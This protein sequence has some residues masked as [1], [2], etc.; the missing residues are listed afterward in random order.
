MNLAPRPFEISDFSGGITDNYLQGDP[1]RS[2]TLDNFFITVDKKLEERPAFRPINATAYTLASHQQRVN[3]MYSFINETILMGSSGRAMSYLP[4]LRGLS[5]WT[6]IT[7]A[8]G[9][10]VIQGGDVNSQITTGEFQRQI[11][12][13]SDGTD[14]DQGAVPSKLYRD[15]GN[16]WTAQTAGLPRSYAKPNYTNE[17]LLSTCINLANNLRTSFISHISDAQNAVS[18]QSLSNHISYTNLHFNKDNYSLSFFQAYTF[19]SADPEPGPSPTPTPAPAATD[20]ASLFTLV[21]ALA[22]AF[23][24]H[25]TDALG[26]LNNQATVYFP[27]AQGF[28]AGSASTYQP[29]YHINTTVYGGNSGTTVQYPPRGPHVQLTNASLPTTLLAAAAQLDDIYQKWNWHR[30]A[31]WTHSVY[32]DPAVFDKYAPTLSK[33]GAIQFT[34]P[35]PTVTPDFS[36][37]YAYTNNLKYLLNYHTSPALI[38]TTSAHKE[39]TDSYWQYNTKVTLPDC[40]DQDSMGLMIFW[41]RSMYQLHYLDASTPNH[42]AVTFSTTNGSA[43]ITTVV[44]VA[45]GAAFTIPSTGAGGAINSVL[46]VAA[47]GFQSFSGQNGKIALVTT[48]GSGTATLDRLWT[49]SSSSF[50]GYV[51]Q[52]IFHTSYNPTTAA[53]IDAATSPEQVTDALVNSIWTYGTEPKSWLIL[54]SDFYNAFQAHTLYAN[55]HQ[56]GYVPATTNTAAYQGV[57]TNQGKPFFIPTTASYTYAFFFSNKYTVEPNGLSY[58]VAGNPVQTASTTSA[59]SLPLGYVIPTPYPT[60]FNSTP[61]LATRANVLSNL[62]VLTNDAKSNYDLANVMLNIYRTIDGGQTYYLVDQVTNGT[63]T[64]SDTSSDTLSVAGKTLLPTRQQIYTTGGNVG[65]DQPPQCKFMHIL[66]GTAYYGAVT[67]SGQFFPNRI[68]QAVQLAPDWC[69]ASFND[70]LDDALTGISSTRSNVV[71]F[72]KNSLYRMVGG[73]NQV[74]QGTLT[75]ERISD[76]TGALNAKSIVRT[77]IGIFF[78]GTDGFYYTDGYQIIKISIDLDKTYQALTSTDNQKRAIAGTYDKVTRRVWWSM[79]VNPTDSENSVVYVFYLNY[80]VKPSGTF[81]T[82]SNYSYFWPASLTFIQGVAYMGDRQGFTLKLDQDNKDDSIVSTS[83]DPTTWNTVAIPFNWTSTAIDMGTTFMKKWVTKLHVVGK[84]TGNVSAIPYVLRD[85]NQSGAG[86]KAMSPINYNVNLWWGNPTVTWGDASVR[87]QTDGKMDLWRWFPQGALRSDFIQ[88]KIVPDTNAVVYSS[89]QDYPRAQRQ[90]A[91]D[92]T[93]K[94]ATIDNQGVF[95]AYWPGDCV[96]MNISFATDNYVKQFPILSIA[97]EDTS[98]G[99]LTFSDPTNLAINADFCNGWQIR[100]AR[101]NQ[102]MTLTAVDLHF[103]FYGQE[104]ETSPGSYSNSGPGSGG[105]NPP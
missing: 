39:S 19:T 1:R 10:Q 33:V 28:P 99:V 104:N 88:L 22:Q 58:L 98:L 60:Y 55:V 8:G 95:F 65:S 79:R 26:G 77:E 103:A 30:K 78:A 70:D 75:H 90:V 93:A 20:Q 102:R 25:V 7:G 92:A 61:N 38:S 48:S 11:Y 64:Y 3:G 13:T 41:L 54:A 71:A 34:N 68:R 17:T 82:I 35:I 69:P 21:Y 52:S 36:D 56:S 83:G 23:T 87:W 81:T 47:G 32:N 100:G 2:Q 45:T 24:H 15:S 31:V 14:A 18:P 43:N 42:T 59:V 96:G 5:N 51:S 94:T 105:A 62:P 86:A 44:K 76:T 9:N 6:G 53:Y 91:V 50:T 29:A 67:D 49:G 12:L 4:D 27:V 72:C 74:G 37:L 63:T 16:N 80:G 97:V 85:L 57:T 40:T 46:Y 89:S 84:N 101:K 66:N 73:F